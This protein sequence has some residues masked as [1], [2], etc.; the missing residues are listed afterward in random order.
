MLLE[1]VYILATFKE[2]ALGNLKTNVFDT[3]LVSKSQFDLCRFLAIV[4]LHSNKCHTDCLP[5]L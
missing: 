3:L 2:P 4:L 1:A 5:E